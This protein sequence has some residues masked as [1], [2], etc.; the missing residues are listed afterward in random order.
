M[1]MGDFLIVF[2]AKYLIAVPVLVL[3]AYFLFSRG[4]VLRQLAWLTLLSLPVAY[5]LGRI[6]GVLY[7]DPR[8][9]VVDNFTP[10]ITHAADNG[11]PSDHT[12]FAATLA[13]IV[14]YVNKRVGIALWIV[15]L[16]IGISRIF[17]GV[18]HTTDII[19]SVIIALIAVLLS[20]YIIGLLRRK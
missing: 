16:L 4:K 1:N 11:F 9:F 20:Q 6:A 15:A 8:P 3:L 19:G 5:I 18:H 12:L 7:N 14:L 10:L 13:M 17:A 2:G